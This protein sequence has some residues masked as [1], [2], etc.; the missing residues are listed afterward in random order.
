M[1]KFQWSREEA[2]EWMTQ[3]N[4]NTLDQLFVLKDIPNYQKK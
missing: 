1:E 2:F 4:V 3:N